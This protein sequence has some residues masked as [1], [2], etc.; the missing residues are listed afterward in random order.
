MAS[1]Q[2]SLLSIRLGYS[3]SPTVDRAPHIDLL[4]QSSDL[5]VVVNS[6]PLLSAVDNL[7][8]LLEF[9][10]Q[11]QAKSTE[12]SSE[13]SD[14][15][16]SILSI[17]TDVKIMVS[18][19]S[20]IFMVDLRKLNR[21]LLEFNVDSIDLALKTGE[22]FAE[23]KVS[24]GPF[25]LD[26]ARVSYHQSHLV[27]KLEGEYHLADSFENIE[28]WLMPFKPILFLE[29]VKIV[30]TGE[31]E[32][33]RLDDNSDFE[34]TTILGM[35]LNINTD[36]F[37]INASPTTI[38]AIRGVISSFDPI[39]QW[40]QGD[41]IEEERL[42]QMKLDENKRKSIEIQ[43]QVLEKV[44]NE[45]DVDGS[46]AI[47]ENELEDGV[48]LLWGEARPDY[49]LTDEERKRETQYL[50][51]MIDRNKSNEISFQD[52]DD[53]IRMLAGNIDD[54]NIVSNCTD[55]LACSDQFLS[56]FQLRKLLY[57]DDL[58]EYSS[59]HIANEMTGGISSGNNNPF[60]SPSLWRHGQGIDIFWERYMKETGCSRSSLNGQSIVAVQRQLVR[61]FW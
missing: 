57:F 6:L 44:W 16:G 12:S 47:T 48:T 21:G 33:L 20:F 37:D 59:M 25:A 30:A 18:N 10:F 8:E 46:G 53:A 49:K 60:P 58:K 15:S 27:N 1:R 43:H 51:S 56:M 52:L 36:S 39:L 34:T 28:C 41:A 4:L 13:D 50:M 55:D 2:E 22:A 5:I 19:I 14:V 7:I 61:S 31:E 42:A 40:A 29:G 23:L 11:T 32:M 54:N 3:I 24:T 17:N 9:P 45:I 38:V 35:N 26:A